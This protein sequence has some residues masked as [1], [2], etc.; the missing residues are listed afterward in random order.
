MEKEYQDIFNEIQDTFGKSKLQPSQYSALA[1]AYIGDAV[2]DL[3]I[4]TI[5]ID[6]GAGHV[7]NFHRMTSS[8]VK[9]E[10]QAKLMKILEDKLT[11]EEVAYYR[12]GRNAKSATSAKN[13]SIVDYRIAT[14]F[15]ALVW[16]L[17]FDAPDGASYEIVARWSD[18][19]RSDAS[20][21]MYSHD[22]SR[23]DA[24]QIMYS[25]DRS[26]LNCFGTVV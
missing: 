9:A 2:Y 24:P 11:E 10:A 3:I 8:V 20:Q 14:G 5:V 15:E 21:I 12:R 17:V 18:R 13:A 4:R 22:R 7:K 19:S 26:E 23:S 6:L 1:L 16:L 25:H